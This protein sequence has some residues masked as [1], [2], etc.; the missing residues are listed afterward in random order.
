MASIGMA[1]CI[2]TSTDDFGAKSKHYHFGTDEDIQDR[3]WSS[4]QA[5]NIGIETENT[6]LYTTILSV[7]S[8]RS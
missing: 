2:E 7:N 4:V 5:Y 6:I 1:A 3:F 8:N